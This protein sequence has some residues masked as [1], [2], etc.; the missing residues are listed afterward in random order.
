MKGTFFLLSK[1]R[2]GS[3]RPHDPIEGYK[4]GC[5]ELS[6]SIQKL[7]NWKHLISKTLFENVC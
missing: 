7:W 6:E 4:I 3:Y 5:F 2:L 1:S